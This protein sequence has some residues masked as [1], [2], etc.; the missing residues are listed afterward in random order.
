RKVA[1]SAS[2]VLIYGE[3]G[4]GKE[5][6]ARAIHYASPRAAR[7]FHAINCAAIPE[8]LLESELFGHEKGA[9]TGAVARKIGLFEEASSSTLFLDEVGDLSTAMQAKILRAL[10]EKEV[11]RVGGTASVPVDVRI[12]AA[13][14]RSLARLMQE[15]KFRED[16]FY[17]LNVLAISLPP[18]RE[19]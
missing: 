10:Q 16:L 15:G 5:L 4:T 12:L 6:I 13:T 1:P 7:P 14:N 17:R 8:P 19:R 2:T 9:F 18:L 11:R 3:S